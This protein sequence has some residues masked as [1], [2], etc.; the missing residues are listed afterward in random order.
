[1]SRTAELKDSGSIPLVLLASIVISG[2]VLSLFAITQ[3]SMRSSERD[4]DLAAAIHVADAGLQDAFVQLKQ[5]AAGGRPAC[6][7]DG[8]GACTGTM[9]D[10]SQFTWEYELLAGRLWRVTSTG[11]YRRHA[12]V[13]QADVGQRPLFEASVITR[14]DF[15]YLGGG[16]GAS[17]TVGAFGDITTNG[18][19]ARDSIQHII[20]YGDENQEPGGSQP[21]PPEKWIRAEGPHLTNIAREA[22]GEGGVCHAGAEEV[23]VE[24]TWPDRGEEVERTIYCLHGT[25]DL[26]RRPLAAGEGPAII[27]VE[28]GGLELESINSDGPA[29]DLQFYVGGG[30]VR[31]QGNPRVAA[32]IY[33][34]TSSC[35][36]GGNPQ[37]SGALVCNDARING[38]FG[39]DDSVSDISSE[40]FGIR[41]WHEQGTPSVA[42]P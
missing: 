24:R 26:D 20:L 41:G 12:R 25:P 23:D 30:N 14:R 35:T 29:S 21:I 33:A 15:E 3:S 32:T 4:R 13:V 9:R 39:R 37:F 1:M 40:V 18:V 7:P 2:V 28:D 6:D 22:F 38:N 11:Q 17:F 27:Y 31:A 8:T 42:M 19:P 10:G 36:F 16:G 34:P 5:A